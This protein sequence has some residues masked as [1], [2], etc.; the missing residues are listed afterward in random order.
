MYYVFIC[1]CFM[2]TYSDY[3]ITGNTNGDVFFY[4]KSLHVLYHLRILV[5]ESITSI[6]MHY[7]KTNDKEKGIEILTLSG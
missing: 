7:F 2:C 1:F 3:I 5:G 6:S 4:D